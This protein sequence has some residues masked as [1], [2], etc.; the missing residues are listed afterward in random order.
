MIGS[1]GFSIAHASVSMY[2]SGE[3]P[4]A[5]HNLSLVGRFTAALYPRVS[6]YFQKPKEDADWLG[7]PIPCIR[8]IG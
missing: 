6:R 5:A 1:L 3:I 7:I 2:S 4:M 8:L